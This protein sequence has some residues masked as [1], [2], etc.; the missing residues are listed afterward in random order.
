MNGD[1]SSF[2]SAPVWILILVIAVFFFIGAMVTGYHPEFDSDRLRDRCDQLSERITHLEAEI[3]VLKSR[4]NNPKGAVPVMASDT[5]EPTDDVARVLET[6]SDR[7]MRS[8]ADSL[9]GIED[10]LEY[11]QRAIRDK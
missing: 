11:I 4:I 2:K 5:G 10:Q 3:S 1:N 8:M 7:W 6:M 9:S